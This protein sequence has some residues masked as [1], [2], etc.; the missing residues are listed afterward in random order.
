MLVVNINQYTR[1]FMNS[2]KAFYKNKQLDIKA[3]TSYE[4]QKQ[5]SVLFKAKKSYDV[6]VVLCEIN[7]KQVIHSITN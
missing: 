1:E 6:T 3:N 4:A 7:N 5:A 2:Y